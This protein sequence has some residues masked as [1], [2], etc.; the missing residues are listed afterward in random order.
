MRF[1]YRAKDFSNVQKNF[2]YA[3]SYLA[4]SV[5]GAIDTT[6]TTILRGSGFTVA[7]TGAGD[8]TVSFNRPFAV[9]PVIVVGM[10]ESA[11]NGD[12]KLHSGTAP[13]GTGFRVAVLTF[14]GVLTDGI[15]DFIAIEP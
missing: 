8:V 4:R 6:T 12:A 9:T 13:S 11:F 14:G 2:D 5:R 10:G 7:K 3:Q 15:F 1:P